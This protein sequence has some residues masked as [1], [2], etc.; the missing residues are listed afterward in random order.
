MKK[1]DI[2]LKLKTKQLFMVL[3]I[4]RKTGVIKD[5]RSFMT[6]N[7]VKGLS[8]EEVEAKQEDKGFAILEA[9]IEN[10]DK[11]EQDIYNLIADLEDKTPEEVEDQDPLLTVNVIKE[12]ISSKLVQNF[13]KQVTE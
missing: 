3:R 8:A 1:E 9:V 12:L 2:E 11:A 5:L 6:N 13:I 4:V 10:L 7:E